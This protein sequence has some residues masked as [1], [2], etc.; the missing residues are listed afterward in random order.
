MFGEQLQ[1]RRNIKSMD[2]AGPVRGFRITPED[3]HEGANRE[4]RATQYPNV[5]LHCDLPFTGGMH[6]SGQ[7]VVIDVQHPSQH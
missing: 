5:L 6:K 4:H 1:F 2:R 3:P 7:L